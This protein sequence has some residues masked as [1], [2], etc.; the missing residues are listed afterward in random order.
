MSTPIIGRIQVLV[1]N[2]N[3][4]SPVYNCIYPETATSQIVDFENGVNY[5]LINNMP[6][7]LANNEI[8]IKK[9]ALQEGITSDINNIVTGFISNAKS[10]INGNIITDTYSTKEELSNLDTYL[11]KNTKVFTEGT[12]KGQVIAVSE[13][14]QNASEGDIYKIVTNSGNTVNYYIYKNSTWQLAEVVNYYTKLNDLITSLQSSLQSQIDDLDARIDESTGGGSGIELADVT[15]I[16]TSVGDSVVKL[17]WTDP[18]GVTLNGA[19]LARWAGTLVVRKEGSAPVDKNDGIVVIDSTVKNAYS[20]TWYEDTGLTNGMTYYYRFFPHSSAGI[21]TTGSSVNA[22]PSMI[23]PNLVVDKN[24]VTTYISPTGVA[25]TVTV[26]ITSD[27]SGSY[28]VVSND[29]SIANAEVSNNIITITATGV[30][31]TT[32]VLTQAAWNEYG[33]ASISINVTI[34]AAV[35]YGYRI[36]ES[37]SDPYARVEYLFDAVG[38]TPAKMNFST[39]IFEYGDWGNEWFITDNKPLMLKYDGTVDYYLDP[40]DYSKK[41][42]GTVSDVANTSYDGNAMAQ[43]PLVWIKRYS[44]NGYNYEIISNVQY[45]ED[46]KAYAHTR[47]DGSIADYF[48]LG[49]FGA[50]GDSNK[51]RSIMNEA[52]ATDLTIQQ[53][54][55]ACRANGINW[56]YHTWSQRE[57][58]RTL[59]ILIGKSTNTQA[60]F[61]I[62]H[63]DS[64]TVDALLSGTLYNKGQFYGYNSDKL[65]VKVFHIE[66][67]WGDLWHFVAGCINNNGTVYVKMTPE[68]QGY[69]ITNTTGYINTGVSLPSESG[70]YISNMNCSEYGMLPTA[71]NGSTSTYYT[72]GYWVNTSGFC[73]AM[74]SAMHDTAAYAGMFTMEVARGYDYHNIAT[75]ATLSCEQPVDTE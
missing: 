48:Y 31:T 41:E 60:I 69:Q 74:T 26:T 72:D 14:P 66:T 21:Y 2:T 75:G 29:T 62:G 67:L 39:G 13:L 34:T 6:S 46:Y 38:K 23:L 56:F 1:D 52:L 10:D 19:T 43:F 71:V 18:D 59:L 73:H 12:Y 44:E 4:N 8:T 25:G 65:Q 47:A 17:K 3:P 7:I 32:V 50:S 54:F 20:E 64:S 24:A 45:D 27:S 16:I 53:Q 61:G 58:I 57:F 49:L 22:M 15:N 51:L 63:C 33:T 37:E 11:E 9:L 28:S 5:I 40:N 70:T 55:T 30:G 36:K 35:R 42:D 68:G